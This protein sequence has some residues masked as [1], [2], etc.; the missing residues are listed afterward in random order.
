MKMSFYIVMEFKIMSS[1]YKFYN[2]DTI[3]YVTFVTVGWIDVF[4]RKKYKDVLVESLKYCQDH[5]GLIIH[6]WVIMT[7]HLHLIISR[8]AN[9]E[10]SD[11]IRDFKKYTAGKLIKLIQENIESR[12]A[13]MLNVF[14]DAGKRN[15]NNK[16]YQLWRQVNHPE[17][18]FS[19]KYLDQ[20]LDYLHINPVVEGIVDYEEQYLYSSAR[21]YAGGNGLLETKF[22]E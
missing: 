16:K 21:D 11:I 22:I 7:N 1:S 20:K 8:Q 17:E 13:W 2:P 10:M 12:K 14:R 3:Y 18:L 9:N 19:N 5:K 15:S 6:G 4:T